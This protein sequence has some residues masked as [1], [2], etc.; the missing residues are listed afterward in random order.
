MELTP[1]KNIMLVEDEEDIR[2][3]AKIALERIGHFNVQYCSSGVEA[4]ERVKTYHPDLILLDMMMP[5]MDGVA[6][7]KALR[8]LDTFKNTPII[9]MTAK[10]QPSE[11]SYYKV[12][13]AAE[14]IS[15]PF[16]PL[17]LAEKLQQ[18]WETAYAK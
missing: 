9:F 6:T 10:V 4:L 8:T 15:K 13:G 3:I 11:I 16:D 14:I 1:L 17:K 5:G 2:A 12:L 7:F 18:I